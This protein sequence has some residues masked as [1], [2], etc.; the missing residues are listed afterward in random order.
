MFLFEK[1]KYRNIVYMSTAA[2]SRTKKQTSQ[3]TSTKSG[4][5]TKSTKTEAVVAA[6]APA[7][8]PVPVP[9]PAPAPAPAPVQNTTA[10]KKT[11]K[12]ATKP[13]NPTKKNADSVQKGGSSEAVKT[14]KPKVEPAKVE[15]AKEEATGHEVR[16]FKIVDGDTTK[17]RFSG[18]KP[19]QAANK[20]LTSIL[21]SKKGAGKAV[22]GKIKFSI[23]ECTRRKSRKVYNYVGE[24]IQLS[25]PME[26]E[27]GKGADK[28][29]ITYKFNNRVMKDKKPV[30]ATA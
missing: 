16:Y 21:K 29:T 18:T 28:K 4:K 7:P 1:I 24:R 19:K 2:K 26:V 10:P 22:T 15:P 3:E 12:Q 17:G 11:I 9:V 23:Q 14:K 13:A 6:P 5:S 30:V 27:I 25:E 20:A 8:A